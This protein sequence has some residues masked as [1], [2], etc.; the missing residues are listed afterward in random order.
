MTDKLPELFA[1]MGPTAVGK[2]DV[3][4]ELARRLD[5]EIVGCDS[6]QVYRGM[7]WLTA[8][9][10]PE[11]RAA[12][13]H[14]LIDCIEPTETFHVARYHALARQA[15]ADIRGRGKRALLVG[16][17][18]LYLKALLDG[19]CDAPSEDPT[20]RRTLWEAIER[21]GPEPLHSR[22][23][24]VDPIAAEKIHP[25]NARRIVRALEVYELT[26]EALSTFWTRPSAPGL[27]IVVLGLTRERHDLY[28]RI[29]RRVLEMI[30]DERVLDD[31]RALRGVPLSKSAGQVH[32]LPFLEP[33]LHGDRG[34]DETVQLWQ[35][36]VRQY[37]KRQG[38]WFRAEPRMRWV[39]AGPGE[40]HRAIVEQLL[41]LLDSECTLEDMTGRAPVG[42][43]RRKL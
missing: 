40:D 24:A 29:N 16:G 38:T 36:Q 18:G 8:S 31:V 28:E 23:R 20:V 10:T 13:A 9:P 32:G 27:P 22:L 26:G 3:A 41:R 6:M 34:V 42:E 5:A 7:A 37:A 35:R 19:L 43:R 30:R 15:I 12:V 4:I 2:T 1:V 21:E 17:T 25:H 39:S 14:H 33:Y 11:Q